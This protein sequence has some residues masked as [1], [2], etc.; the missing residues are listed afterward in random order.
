MADPVSILQ[1]EAEVNA[2]ETARLSSFVG[3][4]AIAGTDSL[5]MIYHALILLIIRPKISVYRFSKVNVR[6]EGDG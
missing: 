4:I 6:T 3:A 2:G 5:F 1:P